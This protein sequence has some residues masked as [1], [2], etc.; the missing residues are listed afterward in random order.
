L[1]AAHNNE[2]VSNSEEAPIEVSNNVLSQ[3]IV[4]DWYNNS[5]V[6]DSG[7][8]SHISTKKD[9][10]HFIPTGES[11]DKVFRVANGN[12]QPATEKRL[13]PFNLPP[14]AKEVHVSPGIVNASLLSTGV[15]A[16]A[17]YT[18]ILGPGKVEIYDTNKTKITTSMGPILSGW[19]CPITKLHRIPLVP[20][21]L[22]TDM[23]TQT[24]LCDRPATEFIPNRPSPLEACNNVYEF[25]TKPELCRFYHA[26]A[27]FPTQATFEQAVEKNFYASWPGLTV[28]LV[29]KHFPESE[30]TQKGHMKAM[31]SGVRSTKKKA[32]SSAN[33]ETSSDNESDDE[34][35]AKP[36]PKQKD[37]Y[38]KI[39]DTENDLELKI[40][41]D[42][43]GKVFT[44]SKRG[45]QY[46]MVLAEVDSNGLDRHQT[47]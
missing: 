23:D 35:N 7:S 42:Q 37:S 26:T 19:Q 10:H 1:E 36:Q 25:R 31:K 21:H 3:E 45:Y 14:E 16:N 46:I 8:T 22:I 38:I 40:F 47:W 13:L 44:K 12:E 32:K 30:E 4:D 28:D 24:I 18:T 20:R 2:S 15:L 5:M 29:C 33:K 6:V 11:S 34:V 41:T 43:T 17:N 39:F 9:A 27:G